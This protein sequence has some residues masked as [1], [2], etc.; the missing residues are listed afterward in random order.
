MG[1]DYYDFCDC[2]YGGSHRYNASHPRFGQRP[3]TEKEK[4]TWRWE[5]EARLE[6][7]SPRPKDCRWELE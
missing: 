1:D 5:E 6:R 7:D 3:L 4:R 2:Q